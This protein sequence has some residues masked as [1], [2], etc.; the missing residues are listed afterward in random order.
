MKSIFNKSNFSGCLSTIIDDVFYICDDGGVGIPCRISD[1][2]N[3]DFKVNNPTKKKI[4][5][6]QIDGCVYNSSDG[7]KCDFMLSDNRIAC[8]IEIKSLTDFSSAWKSDSKKDDALE[9]IISTIQKI[10][11]RFPSLD[12]LNVF[13]IICL[14]PNVPIFTQSIQVAEQ[15]RISRLLTETGCPNLYI[16]NEM[17]FS[18]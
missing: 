10:K 17:T 12:I 9:Q 7:R 1:F 8:F 4:D 11:L 18:N 5:F 15:V 3:Y 16:G 2:S 6:I 14:K 13:G